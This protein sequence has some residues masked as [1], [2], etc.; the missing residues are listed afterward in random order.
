MINKN[1]H[2]L[3]K[4]MHFNWNPILPKSN[5]SSDCRSVD[6]WQSY[7]APKNMPIFVFW[8]L[9]CFLFYPVLHTII[10]SSASSWSNVEFI[11]HIVSHAGTSFNHISCHGRQINAPIMIILYSVHSFSW[12]QTFYATKKMFWAV[13]ITAKYHHPIN[14]SLTYVLLSSPS[15]PPS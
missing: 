4:N 2:L 12:L 6:E 7:R 5:L 3:P 11:I 15:P 9:W 14:L 1:P 8:K 13:P 10:Y